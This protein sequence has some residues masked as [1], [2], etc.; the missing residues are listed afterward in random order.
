MRPPDPAPPLI[1]AAR[2]PPR[3]WWIL[4]SLLL[5]SVLAH[6]LSF[7]LLQVAYTPTV[8]LP[9]PPAEVTLLAPGSPENRALNRWLAMTDPALMTHPSGAGHDA[10]ALPFQYVPSYASAPPAYRPLNLAVPAAAPVAGNIFSLAPLPPLAVPARPAPLSPASCLKLDASL[11]TLAGGALPPVRVT[12]PGG[13]GAGM[14]PLEP[15]VFLVGARAE[16]GA[17]FVFRQ[18]SSGNPVAD[19]YARGYLARLSLAPATGDGPPPWGWAAFYWGA[20]A[21]R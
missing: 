2:R 18:S 15:T 5:L 12:L 20:D 16:G 17:P 21:H 19:E 7:Y 10:A 14:K 4:L 11:A 1:F 8:T 3:R 6:A 13:G 9:P